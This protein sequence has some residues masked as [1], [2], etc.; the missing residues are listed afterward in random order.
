M[1]K[2]Q[3]IAA[4][5]A[6]YALIS[7][8]ILVA[9]CLIAIIH[10]WSNLHVVHLFTFKKEKRSL[11]S[12]SRKLGGVNHLPRKNNLQAMYTSFLTAVDVKGYFLQLMASVA[13]IIATLVII[14]CSLGFHPWFP[15]CEPS[16]HC[17][18]DQGFHKFE[19]SLNEGLVG[20]TQDC[21]GLRHEKYTCTSYVV[22]KIVPDLDKSASK[23][24]FFLSAR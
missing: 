9:A 11:L 6:L 16:R 5:R 4:A 10:L 18:N 20:L 3:R 24:Y 15:M 19:V 17:R 23:V 12:H 1:L 22:Q 2:L 8:A 13:G 21:K 7:S 14:M